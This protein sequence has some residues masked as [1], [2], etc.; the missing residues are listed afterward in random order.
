MTTGYK[1]AILS[2]H[3]KPSRMRTAVSDLLLRI[4]IAP[5]DRR[6][7]L[8]PSALEIVK[9]RRILNQKPMPELFLRSD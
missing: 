7:R 4:P 5:S 6:F 9:R 8:V 3:L 2:R 1:T